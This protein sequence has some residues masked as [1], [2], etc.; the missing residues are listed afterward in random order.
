MKPQDEAEQLIN[1]FLKLNEKHFTQIHEALDV[2]AAKQGALVVVNEILNSIEWDEFEMSEN[3][4]MY[5]EEVKQ[6][7][8]NK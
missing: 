4:V 8:E 6:A 1:K 7:I 2:I 3:E 5:W